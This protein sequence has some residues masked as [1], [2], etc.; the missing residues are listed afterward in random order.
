MSTSVTWLARSSRSSTAWRR[1]TGHDADKEELVS[2]SKQIVPGQM[3][4]HAEA[5]ACDLLMEGEQLDLLD[6]Y[7]DSV[8][9]HI[10]EN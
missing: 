9:E 7:V 8:R 3:K 2:L 1:V 4:H 6:D 10:F 5:E